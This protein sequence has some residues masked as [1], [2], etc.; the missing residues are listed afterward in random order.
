MP[1]GIRFNRPRVRSGIVKMTRKPRHR[2]MYAHLYNELI[3][4]EF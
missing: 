4:L 1:P 3:S 2:R